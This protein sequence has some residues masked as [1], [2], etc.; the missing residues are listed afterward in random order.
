MRNKSATLP[1]WDTEGP[2]IDSAV[3]DMIYRVRIQ[4]PCL[5]EDAIG[6]AHDIVH[7]YESYD[8]FPR[9]QLFCRDSEAAH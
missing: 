7:G 4:G 6:T 9:I 3:V 8:S 2:E 1:K 5:D